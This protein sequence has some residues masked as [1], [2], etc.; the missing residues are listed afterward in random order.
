MKKLLFL[1]VLLGLL[2]PAQAAMQGFRATIVSKIDIVKDNPRVKPKDDDPILVFWSSDRT[3]SITATRKQVNEAKVVKPKD[4][5][6]YIP[7]S[8]T[9]GQFFRRVS[10]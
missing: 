10:Q 2:L 8:P 4:I 6:E 3:V 9:K 1:V 7:L 5:I